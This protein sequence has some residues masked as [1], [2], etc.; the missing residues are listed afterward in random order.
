MAFPNKL[1]INIE[2]EDGTLAE[3]IIRIVYPYKPYYCEDYTTFV[4]RKCGKPSWAL[5]ASALPTRP[6]STRVGSFVSFLMSV[7][8][9][10]A[11]S[12]SNL[13]LD[14]WLTIART[15]YNTT[16][17]HR[18]DQQSMQADRL[19]P[20]MQY[21]VGALPKMNI[22]KGVNMKLEGKR[23]ELVVTEGEEAKESGK[24]A[25]CDK[26]AKSRVR[27][28][29]LQVVAVE[30][31]GDRKINSDVSKDKEDEDKREN[32]RVNGRAFPKSPNTTLS[33]A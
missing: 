13:K 16:R 2:Q 30:K 21:A 32:S 5:V 31:E 22:G 33:S 25:D 26:A 18:L 11:K 17:K 29:K 15:R 7:M 14:G 6:R 3:R 4:H 9:E 10:S 23:K 28:D 12:N 8:I 1:M 19:I 24:M 20:S 27:D